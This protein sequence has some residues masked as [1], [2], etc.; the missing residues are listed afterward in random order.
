MKHL[1]LRLTPGE[2]T[3]HPLF[4]M[5]T[6]REYVFR[7]QMVDWNVADTTQPRLLFAI[8][9]DRNEVETELNS[10]E[11]VVDHEIVPID[12]MRFY[13][14]VWPRATPVSR[15]LFDMYQREDL[16][17]VH[18]ILYK[19]GSAYVSILGESEELQRAVDR[20]SSYLGVTVERV[21]GFHIG[22][23]TIISRLSVRQREAIEIGFELGYYRC[24]RQATHEDIAAR[25]DCAPNTVTVHLQKAEAKVIAALLE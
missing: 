24:P 6:G 7:A 9:G 1:R 12:D 23:E 21:G 13:L 2:E 18:P 3:I 20:F 17:I 25:M 15:K 4:T 11:D 8:E 5:L 22:P 14:D 10:M 16:I 19:S